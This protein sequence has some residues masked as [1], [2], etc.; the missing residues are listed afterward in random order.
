MITKF[1][2][3]RNVDVGLPFSKNFS[4]IQVHANG[5]QTFKFV[6][7]QNA[8]PPTTGL[9]LTEASS[10]LNTELGQRIIVE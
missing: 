5:D 9:L 6:K 4:R 2:R 10:Y 8:T 3:K 1:L 7:K